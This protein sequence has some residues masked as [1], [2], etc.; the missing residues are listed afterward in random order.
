MTVWVAGVARSARI[1]SMLSTSPL[2]SST[3]AVISRTSPGVPTASAAPVGAARNAAAGP[4]PRAA[5]RRW[6]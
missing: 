4:R 6:S 3:T 2:M 5:R 1:P